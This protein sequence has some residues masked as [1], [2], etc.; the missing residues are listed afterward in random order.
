MP[1]LLQAE[2]VPADLDL[3]RIPISEILDEPGPNPHDT[4]PCE[5]CHE[6]SDVTYEVAR[7]YGIEIPLTTARKMRRRFFGR[8]SSA[9]F[10]NP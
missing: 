2:T 9:S 6:K 3:D 8:R 10:P 1:P 4:F 5:R 7:R